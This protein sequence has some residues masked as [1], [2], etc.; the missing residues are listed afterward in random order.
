MATIIPFKHGE[1]PWIKRLRR[2][3]KRGVLWRL[4]LRRMWRDR[5]RRLWRVWLRV[6]W[7][8]RLRRLW[9]VWLI[10][11]VVGA[12]VGYSLV[13]P[14]WSLINRLGGFF[15]VQGQLP[16]RI[17]TGTPSVID[18][19]TLKING[20]RVRLFGI[21]APEIRQKCRQTGGSINCGQIAKRALIGKISGSSIRCK[22]K[23]VDRYGRVVAVCRMDGLDLNSWMVEQGMAMAYTQYSSAY[24]WAETKA[25]FSDK[26]FWQG[27]FESPWEWRRTKKR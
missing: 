27:E 15:E 4:R 5:L 26:G 11:A 19:D 1:N 7:R 22:K 3:L 20:T 10:G 12:T 9:R 25:R 16:G 6:L 14:P 2:T 23:D 24:V 17:L 13:D 18:G 21:D 8:V